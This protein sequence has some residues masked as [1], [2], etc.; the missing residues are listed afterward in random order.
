VESQSDHHPAPARRRVPA[1]RSVA[2]ML[3]EAARHALAAAEPRRP[4]EPKAAVKPAARLRAERPLRAATALHLREVWKTAELA[5]LQKAQVKSAA[6]QLAGRPAA[7]LEARLAFLEAALAAFLGVFPEALLHVIV[8]RRQVAAERVLAPSAVEVG[9]AAP[10]SA[11]LR[12]LAQMTAA[13]PAEGPG[14]RD[15]MA[16]RPKA[17][18]PVAALRLEVV[19]NAAAEVAAVPA[20]KAVR[21]TEVAAVSAEAAVLL[22]EVVEALGA[23]E[24]QPEAAQAG[25]AAEEAVRLPAAR[26]AAEA[27]EAARLPAERDAA[28]ERRLV[29]PGERA[30]PSA[31]RPDQ[32]LLSGPPPVA[33]SAHATP[34]RSTASP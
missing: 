30:L 12:T 28:G 8:W 26:N 19:P 2:A 7:F 18:E 25:V 33:R 3:W 22:S 11:G 20:E 27:E 21:L 14:A 4:A 6:P 29:E 9:P 32:V 5:E 16:E 1:V 34:R 13:L 24:P 17:A 15:E 10:R 31:C 23:G